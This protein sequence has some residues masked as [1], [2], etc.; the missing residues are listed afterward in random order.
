MQVTCFYEPLGIIDTESD[1]L[2]MQDLWSRSWAKHGWEPKI[3]GLAEARKHPLYERFSNSSQLANSSIHNNPKYTLLC[4]LRWLAYAV[5]GGLWCDYDVMNYG[6]RPEDLPVHPDASVPMF[7]SGAGACGF[8]TAEGYQ[9]IID[10]YTELSDEY[11]SSARE[12]VPEGVDIN[13]MTVMRYSHP[14]W[15]N[16]ISYRDPRFCHDYSYD[17][18]E[19]KKLVHF[20]H[21]L[22]PS[23]RSQ[24]I[25]N[26]KNPLTSPLL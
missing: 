24:H 8:A 13:D 22:T 12:S 26:V 14:E 6:F 19:M 23:P 4:Y 25:L 1:I 9:K 2:A 3:V 16:S 17:G 11:S 15:Y 10:I 21:G 20:P 5:E 7:L 18:W